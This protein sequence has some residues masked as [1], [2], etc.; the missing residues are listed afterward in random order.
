MSVD[1]LVLNVGWEL[2]AE[3]AKKQEHE[4]KRR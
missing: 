4:R 3:Q 2:R 1:R